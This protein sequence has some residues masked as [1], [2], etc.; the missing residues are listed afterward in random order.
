MDKLIQSIVDVDLELAKRVEDA[1]KRR[2][3]V[4]LNGNEKKK[5][6]YDAL[7]QEYKKELE[8]KK[9]ELSLNINQLQETSIQELNDEIKQLHDLFNEKENV[10]LEEIVAH[11]KEI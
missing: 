9:E 5:A 7:V 11:C 8:A 1:K 4:Q 3:D 2:T 6:I 10:W